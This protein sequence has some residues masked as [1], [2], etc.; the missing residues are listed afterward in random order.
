MSFRNTFFPAL[1]LTVNFLVA[2]C[3]TAVTKATIA[4]SA[5]PQDEIAKLERDLS[6]AVSENIDVLAQSDFNQSVSWLKEAKSDLANKASQEET[7][8][9]LRKGRG[10][11]NQA[12]TVSEHRAAQAPTLFAARQA[13]LK[14]GAQQH[15]ELQKELNAL[16]SEVSSKA[17]QLDGVSS[18]KLAKL[19]ERY[20]NLERKALI[21]T[22]LGVAQAALTGA[23]DD[24]AAKRAPLTL[25][26]SELSIRNAQSMISANVRNADGY[27]AAVTEANRDSAMLTEVMTTLKQNGQS[28]N[29][30]AAV[31]MVDQDKLIARMKANQSATTSHQAVVAA[32]QKETNRALSVDLAEKNRDLDN[33]NAKVEIQ[34][35]IEQ[36]RA[37]FRSDEAEAFQQGDKLLIRMKNV[38]FASGKSDLP[39]ASLAGLAKV[40]EIAKSLKASEIAV[41]GHTDSVGSSAQN[42]LISESR[43]S[44]VASYF[45]SNGFKNIEVQST[46]FGFT[47][48]IATNKS[49]EGRAQNRRVDIIIT[50]DTGSAAQ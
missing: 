11:L 30:S 50:P 45:R 42:K 13:A 18:D 39:G 31:K 12:Y 14:A 37:Q 36:A 7:L 34:R 6:A 2:G 46:G 5:N 28:M 19:Q 27:Q 20:T 22:Q 33:A 24:G 4:S 21:L 17:D 10:Y 29:E 44:A 48:P 40:S 35:V 25:K 9:D 8:D 49:K 16:N 41:E 3:S 15:P 43:A 23:I 1:V 38:N 47:K 26:K 32:E